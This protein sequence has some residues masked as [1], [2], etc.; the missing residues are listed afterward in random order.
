MRRLQLRRYRARRRRRRSRWGVTLVELLVVLGTLGLL[1]SLTLPAVQSVRESARQTQCANRLRQIGLALH[2]HESLHGD[3][4]PGHNLYRGARGFWVLRTHAPHLDLLPYLGRGNL[5]STIDM[6][7]PAYRNVFGRPDNPPENQAAQETQLAEFLCPSDP[8]S[9]LRPGNNYRAN[10]G[11]VAFP[12]YA[13]SRRD[14]TSPAGAFHPVDRSLLPQHFSDGLSNTVGF[15]ERV[16]GGKKRPHFDPASDFFHPPVALMNQIMKSPQAEDRLVD[17]CASLTTLD[18]WSYDTTTGR[19][20]FFAGLLDTWYN[21]L[22][23]PNSP[24]PDCGIIS[25][26]IFGG[27]VMTAR[28]AHRG[29]VNCVM[30]DASV[31]FVA[32]KIDLAIWRD[33]GTRSGQ[34]RAERR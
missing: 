2:E 4:P 13:Y 20:W 11:V 5:R 8:A 27:G 29:G 32:D 21:H 19:F 10:V 6:R 26:S 17:A 33:L 15:S 16:I 22:L 23:P 12:R 30:M 3:F 18:P 34:Q 1:V 14:S 25:S 31:R 9:P 7:A 28:S 24:V